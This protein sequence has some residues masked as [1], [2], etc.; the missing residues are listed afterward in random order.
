MDEAAFND[1]TVEYHGTLTGTN[2]GPGRHRE[3]GSDLAS[4]SGRSAT[5]ASSLG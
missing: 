5:R 4:K 2:T 3:V 1:E